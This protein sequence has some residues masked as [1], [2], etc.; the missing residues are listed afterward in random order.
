MYTSSIA[1]LDVGKGAV[2]AL[3]DRLESSGFIIRQADPVDRRIKRVYA[4]KRA[5]DVRRHAAQG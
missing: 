2:G 1:T 3:I 5:S 4:T